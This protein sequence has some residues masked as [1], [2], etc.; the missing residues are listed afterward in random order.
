MRRHVTR[1]KSVVQSVKQLSVIQLTSSTFFYNGPTTHSTSG[2][3]SSEERR[4]RRN[5]AMLLVM[6]HIMLLVMPTAPYFVGFLGA[7][8]RTSN[9]SASGWPDNR[10]DAVGIERSRMK[11]ASFLQAFF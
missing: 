5:V 11:H 9:A 10:A 4:Q 2:M 3:G 6:P 8:Q 1:R 7:S